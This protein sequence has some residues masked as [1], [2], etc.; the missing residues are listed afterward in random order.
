MVPEKTIHLESGVEAEKDLKSALDYADTQIAAY[1]RL[2]SDA[3]EQ[4]AG[5]NIATYGLAMAGGAAVAYN[6]PIQ[7][8][9]AIAILL[10]GA[11]GAEVLLSPTAKRNVLEQ[12][13]AAIVCAKHV[14]S[15]MDAA[16]AALGSGSPSST[17][18][19]TPLVAFVR[20]RADVASPQ[21]SVSHNGAPLSS[22]AASDIRAYAT[23][24]ATYVVTPKAPG[25]DRQAT[26]AA[27]LAQVMFADADAHDSIMNELV[28]SATVAAHSA[29]HMLVHTVD[30]ISLNVLD[31]L[32]RS[33]PNT[34]D[35]Y[36]KVKA[37][38][39]QGL[40]DLEQALSAAKKQTDKTLADI[41]A[42]TKVSSGQAATTTTQAERPPKDVESVVEQGDE[43]GQTKADTR[44]TQTKNGNTETAGTNANKGSGDGKGGD[45]SKAGAATQADANLLAIMS[46]MV[47]Q[48]K[49]C[50]A[51]GAQ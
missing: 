51:G 10:A 26:F 33:D 39:S 48:Q 47:A 38:N 25:S 41:G 11:S 31:Q 17:N 32:H 4:Q 42:V 21:V 40:A 9:K 15:T 35:I 5:L 18:Q 28:A 2:Q 44:D 49:Q 13:M 7:S 27:P 30:L 12:G 46:A 14:A 36:D 24:L 37:A 43:S 23:E 1:L 8:I 34:K 50:D 22:N 3:S 29:P 6:S 45:A 16:P 20:A 19:T